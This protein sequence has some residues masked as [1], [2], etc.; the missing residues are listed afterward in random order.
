M[1][2]L[3]KDMDRTVAPLAPSSLP[4]SSPRADGKTRSN[5]A[6]VRLIWQHNLAK[7]FKVDSRGFSRDIGTLH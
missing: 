7:K 5:K 2:D 1:G 3:Q 6:E 4:V